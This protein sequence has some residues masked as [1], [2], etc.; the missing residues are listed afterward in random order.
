M[1]IFDFIQM[2]ISHHLKDPHSKAL[3][4]D[5]LFPFSSDY[6]TSSKGGEE[7]FVFSVYTIMD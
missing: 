1:K 6:D 3:E 5:C 4:S 2:I 7:G